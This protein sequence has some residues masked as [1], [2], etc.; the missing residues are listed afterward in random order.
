MAGFGE[1][2]RWLSSNENPSEGWLAQACH[3]FNSLDIKS[4]FEDYV[5]VDRI[6]SCVHL[7]GPIENLPLA[8]LFLCPLAEFE[9]DIPGCFAIPDCI[10]YWSINPS[11]AERLSAEEAR[12]LGLPDIES[13]ME[14]GVRY[15]DSSVYDGICQFQE[16]KG[17]DPYSP[18]VAIELGYPLFQVSCQRDD[19]FAHLREVNIDEDHSESEEMS[20]GEDH[21]SITA[22]A[23]DA[24]D[25]EISSNFNSEMNESLVVVQDVEIVKG[26][27]S[28]DLDS[29]SQVHKEANAL[30]F[31]LL[32][33]DEVFAMLY[34]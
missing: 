7:L 9:T 29:D 3:I 10:A 26:R 24:L 17:F 27:I 8:Y 21:E 23:E 20:V 1:Y 18:D 34:C 5:L 22:N 15:W 2:R 16:A 30:V 4:N 25:T 28:G 12:T 32:E 31:D 19:I 11:G 13:W 14:V 33:E 6:R